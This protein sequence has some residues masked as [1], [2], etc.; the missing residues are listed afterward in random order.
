MQVPLYKGKNTS[1]LEVNNYRGITLLST[2]NKL[3]EVILW[4]RIEKWWV[5]TGVISQ[6][7]GACRKGILCIHSAYMLQESISTLLETNEKVFVTYLDVTKAF[8]GV[9]IGG[10][11]YRLRK[12]GIKGKLWR[13][14]YNTYV[15]FRCCVRIQDNLSEWYP[16]K[17]G[18]H[19]GGYLSLIKYLVFIDSLLIELEESRTCSVI[20]GISVSPIGY[21][22]DV[23]AACI[24]KAKTDKML[25]IVY[26]HSKKWRYRF[27]PK[28]SAILVYGESPKESAT[29]SK[30]RMYRLGKEKIKEETSYD[31][32]GLKNNS[33]GRG[34]E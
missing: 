1:I 22:D 24:N 25:N 10:L 29:N 16:L 17:C 12:I 9:W 15:G 32:L 20:Y 4:K 23:A 26:E 13:I 33:L 27:N 19:Q 28:K 11:F 21:A 34:Y 18:I 14:L 7:Q 6:Q 30:Y 31:H 3:F 8:D 5:D 2:F